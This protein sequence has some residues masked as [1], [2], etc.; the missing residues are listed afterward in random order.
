MQYLFVLKNLKFYLVGALPLLLLNGVTIRDGFIL[1][2]HTSLMLQ[3]VGGN[4]KKIYKKISFMQFG[5]PATYLIVYIIK[6]TS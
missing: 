5:V 3:L 1:K 4:L 2:V 6:I